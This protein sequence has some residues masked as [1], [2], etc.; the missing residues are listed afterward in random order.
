MNT[1]SQSD[2]EAILRQ[3]VDRYLS[4]HGIERMEPK[5]AL[6][7][8]DGT[9]YDSM[10]CH[11]DAWMKMC[12][13]NGIV[14]NRNEFFLFEGRTGASTLDILFRR[15]FGHPPTPEQ[16][17]ELYRQKT[18][19]FKA[20]QPVPLMPGASE[21]T[22]KC[23][24]AGLKCVLVTGSGQRSLLDK[25]SADYP[26]IFDP[27]FAVTSRD[28]TRGKPDPEPYLMAM[29]RVGVMPAESVIFENAPLGV[30]SGARSGAFTVAV[31][32]GPIPREAFVEAGAS[33][34]FDSMPVCDFFFPRLLY[35]LRSGYDSLQSAR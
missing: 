3:A 7:D 20:M 21:L 25:L 17:K 11:A 22:R 2:Y 5:A 24:E 34:I 28:V 29:Q 26:G 9:L 16:V 12:R 35:L 33:I 23:V 1:Q 27:E 19:W 15:Q 6:F 31:T 13:D 30:E 18:I 14:A 8:M 4:D 10:P 32:T